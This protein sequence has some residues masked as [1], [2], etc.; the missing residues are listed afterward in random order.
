M[1]KHTDDKDARGAA[2]DLFRKLAD[3]WD[4]NGPQGGP[5][6][7]VFASSFPIVEF[8]TAAKVV[9]GETVNLRRTVLV[10]PWEVVK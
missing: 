9:D 2:E 8:E 1:P 6:A 5:S 10:G 4:F 3:E 7:S